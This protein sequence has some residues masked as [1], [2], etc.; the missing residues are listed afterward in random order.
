MHLGCL[1]YQCPHWGTEP[2]KSVHLWR[3]M[4]LVGFQSS[5]GDVPIDFDGYSV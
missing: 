1:A 3:L 2:L 5:M 4:E